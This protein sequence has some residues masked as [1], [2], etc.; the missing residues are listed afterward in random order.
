MRR[1]GAVLFAAVL[2]LAGC[3]GTDPKDDKTPGG[4]AGRPK[5]DKSKDKDD[6]AAKGPTWL[7]D[8]AKLPGAGTSVPKGGGTTDPRDPGFDPKAAAQDALGGRVLDPNGKPARNVY[9]RL[10]QVGVPAGGPA[11][12]GIY[13]NN[14]GYFFTRGLKPGKAYDLT[15]EATQDGKTLT[16]VVQTKVPN[17]ILLIVLRDDLPLRGGGLPA[18][19]GPDGGAFPPTPRPS[20]KVGDGSWAPGGPAT[21]VPPPSIGGTAPKPPG[22]GGTGAIPPPDDLT[23]SPGPKPSKPENVAEGKKD[24]FKPPATSIPGPGGPPVPPL[25]TLPLPPPLPPGGGVRPPMNTSGPGKLA[26][27]DTLERPWDLDSVRPGGL[28]LVEFMTTSCT[29]CPKVIPVLKDMQSRYGASGLQVAGVLCDSLPQK[30]RIATAA[31][32]ARDYNLNYALYVEPGE[33]GSVR[34]QFAVEVYPHAILLNSAGKV[35]WRGHPGDRAKLES[36]IK[37]NLGK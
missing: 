35:L 31:K 11:P 32:Y 8:V 15:A 26:L 36:A 4:I 23:P 28:V 24:P 2:A 27:V 14:E 7:D 34:D 12:I 29:H 6:L 1:A 18:P 19:K 37:Q 25:P 10:E 9:I 33:A 16:G 3:K 21:G 17:P 22:T 20:D 13:T 5:K 30:D